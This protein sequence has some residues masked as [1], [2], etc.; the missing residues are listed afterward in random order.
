MLHIIYIGRYNTTIKR[1]TR[2]KHENSF[3]A[4]STCSKALKIID[5]ISR[6][7]N[8]ILL[9][10]QTRLETDL[11]EIEMLHSKHPSIFMVLVFE[12]IDNE[13]GQKYL[14]AGISNTLSIDFKEESLAELIDFQKLRIKQI[15]NSTT[16][17]K[18]DI[19]KFKLPVWKRCF[20]ITF[21]S[22]AMIC[23]SPL[24]LLTALAIRLESKGAVIYKSKRVGSNYKIFDFLKFRSMYTNADKHLKDFNTL[25]QYASDTELEDDGMD[26]II[27]P[28]G[29]EDILIKDDGEIIL[30]SD[31]FV[32]S[33]FN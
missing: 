31:D 22:T 24:L 18:N 3:Y 8:I 6:K 23:L 30:I 2:H 21:A 5:Q 27:L 29:D 25:N 16:T 19:K 10:E 17:T 7:E 15:K 4:V 11:E 20:D 32:I 14:K 26:D 12:K 28:E 33:V 13:N 9:Y 1:I